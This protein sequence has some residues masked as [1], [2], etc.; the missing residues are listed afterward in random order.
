MEV[1]NP[2]STAYSHAPPIQGNIVLASL[3]LLFWL[4]V[5]PSAWR[6]HIARI[7][8]QLRPDFYLVELHAH[9]WRQTTLRMLLI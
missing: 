7:D 1:K 2:S 3:Q 9:H 6:N 8:P 4:L 5:H